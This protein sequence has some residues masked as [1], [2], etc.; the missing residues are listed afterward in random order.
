M[1]SALLWSSVLMATLALSLAVLSAVACWRRVSAYTSPT[2]RIREMEIRV[3]DLESSLDSMTQTLRRISAR[4]GMRDRRAR[5][6]ADA[7][8]ATKEEA[9]ARYLRG[10]THQE[11]AMAAVRGGEQ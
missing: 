3:A 10:R 7:P 6:S 1:E 8:P 9:R 4:E 5:A 11:I 2:K